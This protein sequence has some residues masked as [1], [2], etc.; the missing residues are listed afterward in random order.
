MALL[1]FDIHGSTGH[2]HATLKMAAILK[3]AGHEVLYAL[4][5]DYK[6][7]V[8]AKG[9]RTVKPLWPLLPSEIMQIKINGDSEAD[10]LSGMREALNEIKP[11][12]VLL[13]ENDSYKAIFYQIFHYPVILSQ[14]M[15]D[16]A[17][18]KG[19]PPF[20]SYH[21]PSGSIVSSFWVDLLWFKRIVWFRVR[22]FY[23]FSF[24]RTVLHRLVSSITKKYKISLF[25]IIETDRC[26]AFGIKG[27]PRLII[28]P[29][30]FDFPHPDRKGVYRIGPLVDI[31]REGHI[32]HPRY[33]LLVSH[34]ER[35]R[36]S[37]EGKVIYVS[38]GTVS[39]YDIGRCTKFYTRMTQVARQLP[40]HLFVLSTGK[41]FEVN[42]LLPIPNNVM[43]FESIPQ[44][45]LLQRCDFM[46]TH[47]GM[48]SITECVFCGIPMLVYP[49]SRN[50]DQPGNSARVVYHGL[51]LCGRIERDSAK[52]ISKKINQLI[53]NYQYYKDNVLRMKQKF[54]EKNNS[55][56]VVNIIESIINSHEE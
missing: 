56:E 26:N 6:Q 36:N 11:D 37:E 55:T 42:K 48:N 14:S 51:G 43:V 21:L 29:K 22:L 25:K 28:S 8:E 40:H 30:A 2:I 31:R 15:P 35:T 23:K 47:G 24:G 3:S 16:T 20:T 1:L 5:D 39:N 32:D 41:F 10:E 27:V 9:F 33:N 17:R 44:V 12:L 34:I 46:I 53:E 13:D 19:I 50:W 45:D 7:V 38:L 49:L 52:K 18:I 54:E 4:P